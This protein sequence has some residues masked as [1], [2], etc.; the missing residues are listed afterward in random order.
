MT[1]FGSS[2][3]LALSSLCAGLFLGFVLAL[4]VLTGLDEVDEQVQAFRYMR[5]QAR[6]WDTSAPDAGPGWPNWRASMDVALPESTPPMSEAELRR[7]FAQWELLERC[8]TNGVQI[9]SGG[10]GERRPRS[11]SP[12]GAARFIR[13]L[14]GEGGCGRCSK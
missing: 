14:K 2:S 6:H 9:P 1:L 3:L 11:L 4:F 8:A 5:A 13:A 7:D 12:E 10:R